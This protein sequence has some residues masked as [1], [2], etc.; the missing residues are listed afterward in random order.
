L[1]A[2]TS[3]VDSLVRGKFSVKDSFQLPDGEV[4]YRVEYRGDTRANFALLQRDL[5]GRGLT[6][7]L[8]GTKQECVL[9]VKKTPP[10]PK[11]SRLPVAVALLTL[12]SIMV[13]ALLQRM[14]YEQLAPGLPGLVV[15]VSYAGTVV[16]LLGVHELGHRY[17]ARRAGSA[18]PTPYI[19]PGIPD[20]TYFLPSL[21]AV[22]SQRS[23]A[24]NR[25]K[26]F[27][28]MLVGPLLAL[29][30]AI[31]CYVLGDLTSVQSSV[32]VSFGQIANTS[33][34]LRQINANL[35]Q[36][37]VDS[38]IGPYLPKAAQ[39]HVMLSPLGDGATVGFLL[40]FIGFL[41]MASFDGGYLSTLA[42]GKRAARAATYLSVLA[43]IVL[44]TPN[45]WALAIAVLVIAGR[46]V[47]LQL[48]DEV[49]D[50]APARRWL[51]LGA[52]LLALLSL[53]IPQNIATLSL[54]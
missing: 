24:V 13:F 14:V 25:D 18:P 23:P 40:T 37:A 16:V 3:S 35:L 44:D 27:D 4:E 20:V 50:L 10:P 9:T 29:L 15:L 51:Y 34:S 43:L 38:V 5:V 17:M 1:S 54:G 45:Y 19:V 6:P 52:L 11:R 12:A 21:G 53:P 36:T 41:P 7:W 26:V 28:V 46:P 42:W 47:Q 2:E 49:S 32:P 39:G 8:Q 30:V 31:L 22:S 48:L 33:I